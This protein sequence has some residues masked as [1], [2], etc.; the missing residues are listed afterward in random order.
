MQD[1]FKVTIIVP[2]FNEVDNLDRIE[3]VFNAFFSTAIQ[4]C[5]VLFIDDGSTD[6]SFEKIVT[7]CKNNTSFEYLKFKQNQGLSSA[8]KAGFDYCNTALVGYIDADL[9][10]YPEDFNLLLNEI[11][12]YDAVVGF[13]AKRKDTLNKKIQS[14][15]GN[16]IRRT[17]IND[18][19]N[20]TGCPLKIIKTE[21]AQRIP[22]FK[23]MHRFIPALI[24]L[25]NG[26]IKQ[27]PVQHRERV[28]GKSKF[29]IKNRSF[30]LLLDIF[31][32]RWMR[33]RYINYEVDQKN[34]INLTLDI[35][36]K[37]NA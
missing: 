3:M 13:R 18:E 23:G 9:Q 25:Q 28:A 15:I 16:T 30:G 29:N 20:D 36:A 33:R 14:K 2:V 21:V 8:I 34:I 5:K 35:N 37:A 31:A 4:K 6:G 22:F 1:L 17:L 11:E 7:I 10:T 32:Y 26:K 19:I 12:S 27:V 24:K